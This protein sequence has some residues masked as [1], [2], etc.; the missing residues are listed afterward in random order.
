MPKANPKNK[1]LTNINYIMHE[2]FLY[3]K[4]YKYIRL[5]FRQIY[6]EIIKKYHSVE[7]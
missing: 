4:K 5:M 2:L 7:M 3:L 6:K 1:V